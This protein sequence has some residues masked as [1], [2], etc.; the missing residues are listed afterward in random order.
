MF[1][2]DTRKALKN[3]EKRESHLKKEPPFSA[4][5]R[6]SIGRI[7]NTSRRSDAGSAWDF[8]RAAGFSW[9]YMHCGG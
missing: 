8:P 6:L 7:S 2:W 3:Y 9:S 4:I 1:S 5:P